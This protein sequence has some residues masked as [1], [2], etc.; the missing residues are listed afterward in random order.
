MSTADAEMLEKGAREIPHRLRG[1]DVRAALGRAIARQVHRYEGILS[2][3]PWQFA[4]ERV[5]AFRPGGRQEDRRAFGHTA[6]CISNRQPVDLYSCH[7][8]NV[9]QNALFRLCH[10][11]SP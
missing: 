3:K 1:H 10:D 9:G 7:S 5:N 4:M 2:G 6:S 11:S 8:A